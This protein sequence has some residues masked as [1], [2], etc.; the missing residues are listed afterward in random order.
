MRE[1]SKYTGSFTAGALLH[2]EFVAIQPF[3]QDENLNDLLAIEIKQNKY[4]AIKTEA[5]RK[6][7]VREMQN[8]II[9]A[10]SSFWP[11]FHNLPLAEQKLALFYLCLKSYLLIF[12]FHFEVV[13]PKWK[14]HSKNLDNY[15]I[16]MRM[17]RIASFDETVY[18]WTEQTKKKLITKYRKILREAGLMRDDKLIKPEGI[19]S[20]FWQYFI[21]L[22][23]PWFIEACFYNINEL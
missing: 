1:K 10:P 17:D 19:T 21:Q 3:M 9:N 20:E 4:L 11:F 18:N 23:E 8:R 2:H 6:R 22:N 16:Q 12:D 5:A 13:A 14:L 7:I 15:D